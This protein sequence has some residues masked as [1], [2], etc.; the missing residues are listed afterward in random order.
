MKI[1]FETKQQSKERQLQEFLALSPYERFMKFLRMSAEM[2]RIMPR[3]YP[4]EKK[5]N[6]YLIKRKD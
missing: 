5:N 4:V 1:Y 6:F 3:K 2:K